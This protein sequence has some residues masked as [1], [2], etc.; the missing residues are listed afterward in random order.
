MVMEHRKW[1]RMLQDCARQ[2]RRENDAHC[3]DEAVRVRLSR[4]SP[5]QPGEAKPKDSSRVAALHQ[6]VLG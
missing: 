3:R 1:P 6:P 5:T 2:P 4:S